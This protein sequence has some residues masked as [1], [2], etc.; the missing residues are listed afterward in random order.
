MKV[1]RLTA[2]PTDT[3]TPSVNFALWNARSI[4]KKVPIVCELVLTHEIDILCI[5]ETWLN[6]DH[7]DDQAIA[8][9]TSTLPNFDIH[10]IPREQREGGGICVCLQKTF[11]IHKTELKSYD[12]FEY[13]YLDVTSNSQEPLRLIIFYRLQKSKDKRHLAPIFFQEFGTFLEDITSTPGRLLI[14]GDFNFH[15]DDLTDREASIFMDMI[16]SAG[17]TQCH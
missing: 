1:T 8:D 10:H 4:K 17:L 15:V 14:T 5:T 16:T 3:S 7:R 9:L 12:S 13:F 11:N 2:T 6:G